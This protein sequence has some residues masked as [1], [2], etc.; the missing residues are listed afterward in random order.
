MPL[1]NRIQMIKEMQNVQRWFNARNKRNESSRECGIGMPWRKMV[2]D[3]VDALLVAFF[4]LYSSFCRW[5]LCVSLKI[6]NL[7][8]CGIARVYWQMTVTRTR[9]TGSANRFF[10]EFNCIR[11]FTHSHSPV[12]THHKNRYLVVG[13]ASAANSGD[14][15]SLITITKSTIGGENAQLRMKATTEYQTN[16]NNWNEKEDGEKYPTNAR[17][18]ERIK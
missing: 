7:L 9:S 18:R 2:R 12:V 17:T 1:P 6:R 11:Y 8:E 13:I 4:Y 5:W 10:L 15:D 14:V 16:N 3:L